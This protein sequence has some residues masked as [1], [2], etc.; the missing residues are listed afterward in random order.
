MRMSSDRHGYGEP[1][2]GLRWEIAGRPMLICYG[3]V[4]LDIIEDAA[5]SILEEHG[6]LMLDLLKTPLSEERI[7]REYMYKVPSHNKPDFCFKCVFK[8]D[9]TQGAMPVTYVKKGHYS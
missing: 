8:E 7:K 1:L 9:K 5:I 4:G 3:H 2:M 6:P